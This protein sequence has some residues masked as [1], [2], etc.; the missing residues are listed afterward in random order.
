MRCPQVRVTKGVRG[1]LPAGD[2]RSQQH[3]VL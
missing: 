3:H 2:H 1:W